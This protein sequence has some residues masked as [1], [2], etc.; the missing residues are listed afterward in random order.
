[1]ANNNGEVFTKP[2]V[3]DMMLDMCG[4]LPS[5]DLS[6]KRVLEPS[7]GDGGFLVEI[8]RRLCSSASRYGIPDDALYD[9]I[10]A[11]DIDRINVSKSR[12]RISSILRS[13][14]WGERETKDTVENWVRHDDFLL[15]EI[16]GYDVVIG[17]PPYIRSSDIPIDKREMYIRAC[18]TM[19]PGTDLFIG[20]IERGLK[21]MRADGKLCYICADRWMQN[22]YGRKLRG[23]ISDRH[24]MDTIVRMHGVDAFDRK[25]SAYPAIILI[26][27]DKSGT[28]FADCREMFSEDDAAE[29]LRCIQE[30]ET[31]QDGGAFDVNVIHDL[32]QGTK[33]WSLADQKVLDFIKYS[34]E[35]FPTIED[36]GVEIGIGIAT[37]SDSVFVSAAPGIVEPERMLPLLCSRDIVGS[38]PPASPN[39]WLVNPWNPDGTL[40]DLSDYPMLC[41][42]FESNR[43]SL[44]RRHIA[45]KSGCRWYRT[46]DKIKPGLAGAHKLLLADMSPRSNPI[47]EAGSYYPH[48]NMYWLTSEAWDLEVLGGLLMSKQTE[49][50]VEA[51]GVKMRGKTMRFQAQYLRLL[52]L[53]RQ[54][55]IE[56]GVRLRLKEAFRN[57]DP[58]LATEAANYAFSIPA[59]RML[60]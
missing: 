35:E 20:F 54:S 28:V 60:Y 7:S 39:H 21:S 10:T 47:Y 26:D 15:Q 59:G 18:E 57:R 19:T 32:E 5:V 48:H 37:G 36:S 53:P 34:S 44:E 27:G 23:Y 3:A 58:Q 31:G 24:H 55:D 2:W 16:G 4:Y 42:Y 22:S 33:P 29:L 45:K 50:V 40:V 43:G 41:S 56:E 52:H 11:F 30:R 13:L 38:R 25:V 46:I 51:Y 14:G 17:N 49:S 12:D 1:M 9:S 6:K 8:V